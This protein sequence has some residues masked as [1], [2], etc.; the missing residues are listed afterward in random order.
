MKTPITEI[1]KNL[2]FYNVMDNADVHTELVREYEI[3]I[4]F[5]KG[6]ALVFDLV[7]A[8]NNIVEESDHETQGS[9]EHKFLDM[10]LNNLV[11]IDKG[12][13]R[14]ATDA[15][16]ELIWNHLKGNN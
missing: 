12:V 2:E 6:C 14:K 3:V 13:P 4:R 16:Y 9:V 7:L 15:E 5:G 10:E 11:I 1:I 8:Y